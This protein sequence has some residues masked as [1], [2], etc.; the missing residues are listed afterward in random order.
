MPNYGL[1][2]GFL[3]HK[4]KEL[5]LSS[6]LDMTHIA[7]LQAPQEHTDLGTLDLWAYKRK[8]DVPW[9]SIAGIGSNNIIYE[10]KWVTYKTPAMR[11]GSTVVVQDISGDSQAGKGKT[12]F[13]ILIK[14]NHIG[15]GTYFK[16]DLQMRDEFEVVDYREAGDGQE[17]ITVKRR[18]SDEP[19]NKMWLDPGTKIIPLA[20]FMSPEFGQEAPDFNMNI[21]SGPKYKIP[22]GQKEL[23]VTYQVTSE[24]AKLDLNGK[25][26]TVTGA[27]KKEMDASFEYFFK[28]PGLDDS[29][30]TTLA[31]VAASPS[32]SLFQEQMKSGNVSIS[33]STLYDSLALKFL[34]RGEQE[35][36][37]WGTGGTSSSNGGLDETFAPV[38]AWQQLDTGYKTSFNVADFGLHTLESM[39]QEYMHGKIDYP[40]AGAE[41]ILDVQTGKGGFQLVQRMI[42]DQK[43]NQSII[44][45]AKDFNSI[46]GNGPMNLEYSPLWFNAIRIPM[47]AIFRFIYN[48]AFDPI[49][50]NETTNPLLPGGYR[51][52][53]YNMIVHPENALNGAGN[54]KIIRSKQDGGKVFMN[55][56]NGRSVGH[57]L[58]RV[59]VNSGGIV[60]TQSAHLGSGYQ[61]LFT[62][63]MDSLQILDP[64]KILK[65]TAINPYTKKRY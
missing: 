24:V 58:S 5:S 32:A 23:A 12:P 22:V 3:V 55:V 48:P 2:Q 40:S 19:I 57:P 46:A 4:G 56:I 49:E 34:A 16:F 47:L 6:T 65:A 61:A 52:S 64:T 41:P 42:T 37:L 9:L 43:N 20:A 63:K 10:D 51:L 17:V 38:G 11:D 33:V 8:Q 53:S 7:N 36:Q 31:D 1:Q 27:T 28:V 39:Y 13:E 18:D 54:I 29:G 60:A 50:A 59:S 44:V 21:S 30:L 45:L 15:V 14:G 25:S 26:F 35:Y 62:K